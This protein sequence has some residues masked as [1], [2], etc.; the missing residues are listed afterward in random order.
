MTS[1]RDQVYVWAF[2]PGDV[3]PTIC[4]RLTVS[5]EAGGATVAEFIYGSSYLSR[6]DA[7]ALDPIRL[8]LGNAVQRAVS[9]PQ[10]GDPDVFGV[11]ADACPDDWG[12]Y[13]INRRHG[14]QRFPTGYLLSTQEDR[15]GNLCFSRNVA[16][17]PA[18][19]EPANIELLDD[20]WSV[21]LGLDTG[22]PLPPDLEKRVRANTAIGGARPKLTI[23][24]GQ[25]QWLAKFPSSRDDRRYAQARLEAATLDLA[26][27]CGIDASKAELREV[28]AHDG[29]EGVVALIKRFDRTRHPKGRGWLREAYVSARTVLTS[30]ASRRSGQYMG[31]YPELA[32]QLQRWSGHAAADRFELYRRMVFNCCVSNTDDHERNH[33]LLADD[34][35][36][37]RLSPAF[38]IVPR[39]SGTRRR[40]QAMGIGAEGA[41]A[42]VDN[43]LSCAA[44]FGIGARD[45]QAVIDDVQQVVA[46]HWRSCLQDRGMTAEEVALLAPC[47]DELPRDG[48]S[49]KADPE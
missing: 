37:L 8:P 3:E 10:G 47:F 29:Q 13:V 5:R 6:D 17:M 19:G 12:R 32:S 43:L 42:T 35:G 31:T 26:A 30:E 46:L 49:I 20:A 4:G 7:V 1:E 23:S 15:V 16:E 41:P 36:H 25:T 11:I 38:D 27:R 9:T 28:R 40:E 34:A 33:G 14:E 24:D 2:L 18:I 45:A 44:D 48:V 22:K 39:L 21:V